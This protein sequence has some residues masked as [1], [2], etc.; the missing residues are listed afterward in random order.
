MRVH[1]APQLVEI[2]ESGYDFS[3]LDRAA[4]LTIQEHLA[5]FPAVALIGPR[6]VG[7]TTLAKML[8]AAQDDALY[9]DLELPSHR[10]R[11]DPSR[12]LP[13]TARWTPRRAR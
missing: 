13:G 8:L 7:K 3:M 11:L 2:L 9:L 12:D 6:Q 1:L 10:D 4:G 5:V